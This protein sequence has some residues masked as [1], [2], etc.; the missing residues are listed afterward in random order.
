ME[1]ETITMI[2]TFIVT[3]IGGFMAKNNPKYN[4]KIIPLQNLAIGLVIAAIEWFVTKDFNTAIALSG[5]LAG[6]TY[7]VAHNLNKLIEKEE[8]S[9]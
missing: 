3:L 6:G 8:E 5:L 4:N 1:L 2:V 7:D 9:L